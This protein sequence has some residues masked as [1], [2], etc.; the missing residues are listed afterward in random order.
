MPESDLFEV[1]PVHVD[2]GPEEMPGYKAGRIICSDC[3]EGINFKREVIV[4]DRTLCK[5]CAGERYY[6]PI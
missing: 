5:S 1:Q 2:V 4:G 6:R 3:G